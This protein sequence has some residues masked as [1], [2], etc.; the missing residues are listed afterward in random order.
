MKRRDFCKALAGTL[1]A[2][3]LCPGMTVQAAQTETA[4][5][6]S[7]VPDNYYTL[8]YR[9]DRNKTD[10]EHSFYYSESLFDHAATEY[11]NRLALITL[12]MTAA[13][14]S[15][16]ASD[17]QYWVKGEVG[18]ADNI[19]DA[20]AKLGFAEVELF[21]YDH[22]LNDTPHT[23][24]CAIG[25]KTLVRNGKRVT[26]IAA[27]LR[28]G[29]YGAEWS[30]NF[31]AG[32]GSAHQG[33]VLSARQI[34]GKI[35]DYVT[36]MS[37][38][39]S[40]GTLK[41]WLGGFSRSAAVANLV[42]ARL[43]ALLSQLSKSRFYVYT[44][45]APASLTATDCP[46]LRQNYDNNHNANGTLKTSWGSSNIFNIIS[47]GDLVPRVLPS[48]W[49][50]HRNG[51]DRFLP[52]T[53][54]PEE[55]EALNE[56]DKQLAGTPLQFDML[57]TA[58]DTD[59]VVQSLVEMFVSRQNYHTV[60]EPILRCMLQCVCTRSKEEVVG[61]VVLDDAA[62]VERL[63]AMDGMKQ[64][65]QA[66]IESNVEKASAMCRPFLEQFGDG[67]PLKARQMAIP[68]LAIGYCF[69]L[70]QESLTRIATVVLSM[71]SE[72]GQVGDVMRAAMCHYVDNYFTLL[73]YYPPE[74]H[75]MEPYTRS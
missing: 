13:A 29:G 15:T 56:R 47:S 59:A 75:G 3:A 1:A 14:Y 31:Y 42:A 62:V 63:C 24:G 39:R 38:K 43:P 40:L 12:G 28:G 33:F 72:S 73:E 69:N 70:D 2:G 21:N 71:V 74:E 48:A 4:L 30:D 54:V 51:N 66:E 6:G 22:S 64:F 67:V 53:R 55:L 19:R 8:R 16:Y 57:A 17:D 60:Y 5:V 36:R 7:V 18:R 10:T 52:S 65:S 49:G 61:G 46:D 68:I 9:D 41:F 32:E 35:Q 26:L 25:R 23:V 58:E 37:K 45:A 20:F 34:S 44:F 27:F 11:D 50:F